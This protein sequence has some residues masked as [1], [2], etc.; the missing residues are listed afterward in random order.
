MTLRCLASSQE[1]R[2]IDQNAQRL[3]HLSPI[4]LMEH[5]GKSLFEAGRRFLRQKDA[6]VLCLCGHGNNGG[7]GLVAA[8][9]F[10]QHGFPV[11]I[12]VGGDVHGMSWVCRLNFECVRL[13]KIPIRYFKSSLPPVVTLVKKMD[14]FNLLVDALLGIGLKGRVKEPYRSLIRAINQSQR[15][16]ISADVPSGL[17]SDNGRPQGA[18]VRA[19]VTV[20]FALAKK[21]LLQ[22]QAWPYVGKLKV[23][24]IGIPRPLTGRFLMNADE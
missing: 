5:A 22:K 10:H 13:L 8:R 14:R 12:W 21:G 17:N 3:Y 15:P 4:V 24:D 20:S 6:S 23:A 19:N 11:E 9:F 1:A 16:I 7:D 2:R 18:A